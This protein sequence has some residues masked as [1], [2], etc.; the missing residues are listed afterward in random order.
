VGARRTPKALDGRPQ[1]DLDSP[2]T[3]DPMSEDAKFM[4]GFG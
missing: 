3:P 1:A 4:L 2:W